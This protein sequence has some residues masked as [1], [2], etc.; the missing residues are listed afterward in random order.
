MSKK[1]IE[2][3]EK[4]VSRKVMT[5]KIEGAELSLAFLRMRKA[6]GPT[7]PL[8]VKARERVTAQKPFMIKQPNI[9]TVLAAIKGE[10][11]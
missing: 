6:L 5:T 1:L 9:V 7:H 4:S 2:R 8:V 11:G 10:E 3:L